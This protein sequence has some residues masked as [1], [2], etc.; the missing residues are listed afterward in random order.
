MIR[1]LHSLCLLKILNEEIDYESL[2]SGLVK[3]LNVKKTFNFSSESSYEDDNGVEIV[4]LSALT[5]LHFWS[6][7]VLHRPQ[8]V[9]SLLLPALQCLPA[10]N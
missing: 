1:S 6:V 7:L 10:G 9:H 2:P 3:D 5:I 8:R 4:Q